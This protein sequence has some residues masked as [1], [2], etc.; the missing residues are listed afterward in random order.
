[1]SDQPPS[2]ANH[3]Q[4]LLHHLARVTRHAE[5][6][7]QAHADLAREHYDAHK[8]TETSEGVRTDADDV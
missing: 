5:A 3:V 8:I 4:T 6:T 7:E 1:M 2:G